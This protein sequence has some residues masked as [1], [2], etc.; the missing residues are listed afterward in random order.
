M[1]MELLYH[2]LVGAAE[3]GTRGNLPQLRLHHQ[4]QEREGLPDGVSFRTW[5]MNECKDGFEAVNLCGET[6]EWTMDGL[7]KE[8]NLVSIQV[9][10]QILPGNR[11]QLHPNTSIKGQINWEK[12]VSQIACEIPRV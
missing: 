8:L 10:D 9:G 5:Q 11:V 6:V 12:N 7:S 1:L 2:P 4:M 3:W